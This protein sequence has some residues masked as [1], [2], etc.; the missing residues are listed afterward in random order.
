M[1]LDPS[2]G[3]ALFT[4]GSCWTGDRIGGWAYVAIDAFGNEVDN[5]GGEEDVTI[6]RME[7]MALAIGLEEVFLM[8]DACDVLVFSDSE[9]V[10][11]G[12][13]DKTRERKVHNDL[14]DWIDE[15]ESKHTSVTYEHVRGHQDSYYNDLAD[16]LAGEARKREQSS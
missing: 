16:R 10:V 6:S 11:L 7:L 8:L 4:D 15:F 12:A 1:S 2:K 5:S 3:I 9:Y 14:W 13:T